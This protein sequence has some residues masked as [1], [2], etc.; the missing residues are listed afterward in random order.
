VRL[1]HVVCPSVAD[2]CS[3]KTSS[4]NCRVEQR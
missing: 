3:Y 4:T 1:G 2:D